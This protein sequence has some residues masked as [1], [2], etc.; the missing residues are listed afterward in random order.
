[1]VLRINIIH[2]VF[3]VLLVAHVGSSNALAAP[4]YSVF[5]LGD[6]PGGSDVSYAASV[7]D[8]RQVVGASQ[9]GVSCQRIYLG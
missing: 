8:V 7:N 2:A 6:L 4:L 5:D 3:L 1:M 9:G